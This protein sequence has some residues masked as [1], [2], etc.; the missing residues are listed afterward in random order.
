M[1]PPHD[2]LKWGWGCF[3]WSLAAEPGKA[4]FLGPS[5]RA[6]H[7]SAADTPSAV[8]PWSSRAEPMGPAYS[9]VFDKAPDWQCICLNI[10]VHVEKTLCSCDLE[11]CHISIY[12]FKEIFLKEGFSHLGRE[13]TS[14]GLGGS[15][16]VTLEK[17]LM[18]S[19]AVAHVLSY[20]KLGVK[21][22][23]IKQWPR[24]KLKS[25]LSCSLPLPLPH[26]SHG[27]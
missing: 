6:S 5:S 4:H 18:G 2:L 20:A 13:S 22:Q 7:G 17:W 24:G 27:L 19:K 10:N 11:W 16:P 14:D 21:M 9:S 23:E 26:A 3:T 1:K 12:P 8:L 25:S 15:Q